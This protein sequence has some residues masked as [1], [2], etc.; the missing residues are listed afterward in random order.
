MSTL[1]D[2]SNQKDGLC[3][4]PLGDDVFA[5]LPTIPPPALGSDQMLSDEA[6]I[7]NLWAIDELPTAV[8]PA[9]RTEHIEGAAAPSRQA[10]VAGAEDLVA[11]L[12]DLMKS[13]GSYAIASM[14]PPLVSLILAPFLTHHLSP[15]DYGILAILNTL[16]SLGAGISQLGLGS[17][18]F[19]A[20]GYD[21]TSS[22]DRRYVLGTVLIL[23]CLGSFP[24]AIGVVIMAPFLALLLFGQSSLSGFVILAM[25]VI[26]LRN[27]S[28]PG[29]AWLRVESR[30]LL[31]SLL[32]I[33]NLM[34]TL[35]ANIVLVGKLHLGLTGS[36]LATG[37]GYA[38]VVICTMP[39]ILLRAALRIRT[40]IARSLLAFGV[41]LI[42]NFI[43]IWVLELA[44]RYL[45]GIFSSFAETAMYAVAYTLG[46]AMSI[47]VIG[48]F[49]LAW[50]TAMFSILKLEYAAHRFN[51]V[52]RWLGLFLLF[53]AFGLSLVGIIVLD[54]LFPVI[55]HSGVNVIPIVAVSN[56]FY[57]AYYVFS[58]GE[59]I[60]RKTWWTPIFLAVAALDNVGLNLV[61]I[62]HYGAMGAA[63][64][65]L[66]AYIVLTLIA[67]IV[68]QRLYPV[69]FEI[70][71]FLTALLVGTVLYI[72]SA[73]LG[74]G[75]GTYGAWG[76]S[77]CA[78]IFYGGCLVLLGKLPTRSH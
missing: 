38:G 7:Q 42:F 6:E 56:A 44:D 59:S 36:L 58:V 74:R 24:L 26:L 52:F 61:L 55:Y 15:S 32:S 50:P 13:S 40:D 63:M 28:I 60:P 22:A 29:F 31:Y 49:T 19:R 23:L 67:Y 10:P 45:L 18:F 27:L 68:N 78:L 69:P 25:G 1:E 37:C 3:S 20:Y 2:K 39:I 76:I 34:I 17:A 41:P 70:S 66:I 4:H 71:I 21:Y 75:L 33:G 65:T 51:L 64:A 57:G 73:F 43:A 62:P 12:R 14:A 46:S 47:V 16:I 30:P 5:K 53:A 54:L 35:V 9:T 72:G 48:P 77:I 8:L 11:P